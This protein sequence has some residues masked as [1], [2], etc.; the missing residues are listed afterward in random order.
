V[1]YKEEFRGGGRGGSDGPSLEGSWV[2][3][4]AG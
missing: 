1:R 2:T 3:S 4:E